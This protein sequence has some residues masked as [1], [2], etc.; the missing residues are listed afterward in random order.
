MPKLK[1]REETLQVY[2]DDARDLPMAKHPLEGPSTSEQVANQQQFEAGY[3]N[4]SPEVVVRQ[5]KRDRRNQVLREIEAKREQ[6]N[7]LVKASRS[8]AAGLPE[9]WVVRRTVLVQRSWRGGTGAPAGTQ[10]YHGDR[11]P[12]T[13]HHVNGFVASDPHD[14][15]VRVF[16]TP[17]AAKLYAQFAADKDRGFDRQAWYAIE[18]VDRVDGEIY[19]QIDSRSEYVKAIDRGMTPSEAAKYLK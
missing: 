15:T 6:A 13:I 5:M 10:S 16:K 8:L 9:E 7:A 18:V 19:C 4:P 1:H 11:N 12:G 17:A 14:E 2:G 3:A